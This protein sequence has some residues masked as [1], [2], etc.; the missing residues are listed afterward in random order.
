MKRYI[1]SISNGVVT[2][3]DRLLDI[4][5][6]YNVRNRDL[7]NIIKEKINKANYDLEC[8]KIDKEY[9]I[10]DEPIKNNYQPEFINIK[11][12]TQIKIHKGINY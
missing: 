2:I 7:E 1:V 12:N 10:I 6:R 9:H 4:Q 5:K 8:Y 3:R 11:K